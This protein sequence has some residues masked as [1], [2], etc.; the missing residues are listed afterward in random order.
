MGSQVWTTKLG[1]VF[2]LFLLQCVWG[3]FLPVGLASHLFLFCNVRWGGGIPAWRSVHHMHEVLPE[4]RRGVIPLGLQLQKLWASMWVLEFKPRFSRRAIS[5]LH[6]LSSSSILSFYS[7]ILPFLLSFAIFLIEQLGCGKWDGS[8]GKGGSCLSSAPAP[9]AW[10][11][12]TDSCKLS[13]DLDIGAEV[14]ACPHVH[15]HIRT[16]TNKCN[17]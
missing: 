5:A 3:F 13:S 15:I 12:S 7:E 4:T 17:F 16:P 6:C 1:F 9:T 2:H 8:A 11:E 10:K 14:C